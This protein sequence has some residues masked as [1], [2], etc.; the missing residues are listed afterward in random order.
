MKKIWKSNMCRELKIRLFIATVES[1]LYGLETWTITKTLSNKIDGCYTRMLR[2]ALDID[3]RAHKTNK[4]VYGNLPRASFKIQER[5]MKL[6]GHLERHD[7]LIA[8]NLVLWEPTQGH[9]SRGRPTLTYIDVLRR[10]IGL[11][12]LGEIKG[13]MNDR[14]LWRRIIDT[15]TQEPPSIDR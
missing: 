11:N 6:A 5:R 13:L 7:D 14:L 9:R 10:D 8:H 2:M 3:W 1:I 4:E 12:N 15:R